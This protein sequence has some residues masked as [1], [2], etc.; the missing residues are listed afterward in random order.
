M[1]ATLRF[2]SVLLPLTT[3]GYLALAY[4]V[5]QIS[6]AI[7][8]QNFRYLPAVIQNYT[9]LSYGL[10]DKM[11]EMDNRYYF[12]YG[13]NMDKGQMSQR[14]PEA[15]FVGIAKLSGYRFVI[16]TRG[17]ATIVPE[18]SSEVYGILW[19]ITK[20]EEQ[21]LD[22]YEGVKWGTYKK[23][24]V[25]VKMAS[26]M[27]VQAMSY[28]ASN[29]IPGSPRVNYMEKIIAAGEQHGLP[30]KYVRELRSWL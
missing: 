16:N 18:V 3:S 10:A 19:N 8:P 20:V 27:S 15:V 17:V 26:G 11:I 25:S 30:E 23:M 7:A 13:S 2:A 22:S 21:A 12:A 29:S 1:L 14:C 9:Y 5:A 6:P 4:A 28:V 24:V